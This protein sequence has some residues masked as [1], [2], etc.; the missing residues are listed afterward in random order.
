MTVGQKLTMV[1]FALSFIVVAVSVVKFGFYMD[2]MA[3]LAIC[4]IPYKKWLK[5]VLPLWV[6]WAVVAMVFLAVAA[7]IGY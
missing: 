6:I 4:H 1:V 3:A 2:E 7:T 5:F